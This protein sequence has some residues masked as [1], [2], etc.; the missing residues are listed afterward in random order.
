MHNGCG[1]QV[2]LLPVAYLGVLKLGFAL[3]L[4]PWCL[5]FA[6]GYAAQAI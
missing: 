5:G 6:V 4:G 2:R 1:K 3:L